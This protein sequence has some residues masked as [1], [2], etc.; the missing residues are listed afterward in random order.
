MS[1]ENENNGQENTPQSEQNPTT[2]TPTTAASETT[3][4]EAEA[5]AVPTEGVPS[6]PIAASVV[7]GDTIK[8]TIAGEMEHSYEGPKASL[9]DI[10]GDLAGRAKGMTFRIAKGFEGAGQMVGLDK[11]LPGSVTLSSIAKTRGG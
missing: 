7:T 11:I 5:T 10:L 1:N 3:P 8:V 6:E 2:E 4:Q 9:K